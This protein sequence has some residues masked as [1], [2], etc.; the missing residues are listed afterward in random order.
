[1]EAFSRQEK[2]TGIILGSLW[3]KSLNRLFCFKFLVHS[4][5]IYSSRS[6]FLL[7]P[8]SI[9][10]SFHKFLFSVVYGACGKRKVGWLELKPHQKPEPNIFTRYCTDKEVRFKSPSYYLVDY[11]NLFLLTAFLLFLSS[12]FSIYKENKSCDLKKNIRGR[13]REWGRLGTW[14]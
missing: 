13:G 10:A 11:R 9:Q 2:E 8:C 1:M 6:L 7:C 4:T 5:Q 3:P 12:C 14:G